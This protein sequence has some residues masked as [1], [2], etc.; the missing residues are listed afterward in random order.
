MHG[1]FSLFEP[2][3]SIHP[4]IDIPRG[5]DDPFLFSA[6]GTKKKKKKRKPPVFDILGSQ[7]R[8]NGCTD[9]NG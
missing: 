1:S 6:L 8:N 9:Y 7:I 2:P 3:P 5:G 4:S